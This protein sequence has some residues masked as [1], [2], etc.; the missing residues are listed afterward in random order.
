MYDLQ[1]L[2]N[3]SNPYLTAFV[4]GYIGYWIAYHGFT[5][6]KEERIF[7]IIVFMI[8]S[9]L[10]FQTIGYKLYS[11]IACFVLSILMASIYRTY[12][13]K[14]LSDLFYKLQISNEDNVDTVLNTIM[15]DTKIEITQVTVK[16]KNGTILYCDN[17]NNYNASGV[18]LFRTDKDGNIALYVE[19]IEHADGRTTEHTPHNK[20]W[21]DLITLVKKEEIMWIEFRNKK[22]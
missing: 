14:W 18:D 12:I 19:R 5:Y 8:P 9:L 15:Q 2:L 16:L 4:L 21:G 3:L 11:V 1:T 20:N 7:K 10:I 22:K 13:K 17:V 6:A